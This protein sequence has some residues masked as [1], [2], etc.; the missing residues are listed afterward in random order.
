MNKVGDVIRITST[1]YTDKL[2]KALKKG[3]YVI[4]KVLSEDAVQVMLDGITW[5]L[6]KNCYADWVTINVHKKA[7]IYEE[8]L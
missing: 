8:V 1:W 7:S 3:C 4:T 5:T 6:S 2:D